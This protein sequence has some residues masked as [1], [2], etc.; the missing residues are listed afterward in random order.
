MLVAH[1]A[2]VPAL[3]SLSCA[4]SCPA[5][6]LPLGS[7]DVHRH[8]HVR[9]KLPGIVAQVLEQHLQQGKAAA[10]QAAEARAGYWAT[11]R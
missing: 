11:L 2:A 8:R 5:L 9:L 6:P 4:Y 10:G 1:Y 3:H 7:L